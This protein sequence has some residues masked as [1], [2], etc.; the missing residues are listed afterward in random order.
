MV[1]EIKRLKTAECSLIYTVLANLRQRTTALTLLRHSL[2]FSDLILPELQT[3]L[4]QTW[5]TPAAHCERA[6]RI[7][8]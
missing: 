1:I 2:V 5:T 3:H 6:D 7:Y 8:K 4:V